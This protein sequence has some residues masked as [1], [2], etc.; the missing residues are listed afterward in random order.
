[1]ALV[2]LLYSC[3]LVGYLALRWPV[4]SY[5]P[6]MADFGLVQFAVLS[7]LVLIGAALAARVSFPK[8]ASHE[9]C[10]RWF[11]VVSLLG[12][13]FL[14]V[15]IYSLHH[16][17]SS[18]LLPGVSGGQASSLYRIGPGK[19]LHSSLDVYYL[20]SVGRRLA[21]LSVELSNSDARQRG[22]TLAGRE[23]VVDRLS[24]DASEWTTELVARNSPEASAALVT[25][26]CDVRPI[27]LFRSRASEF[28]HSESQRLSTQLQDLASSIGQIQVAQ[29]VALSDMQAARADQQ[30]LERESESVPS[31]GE[32]LAAERRAR[33]S[34]A[35]E[36][37][38]QAA[39]AATEAQ[40]ELRRAND[41][42]T[43]ATGRLDYL[44]EVGQNQAGVNARYPWLGLPVCIPNGW[45]WV[46][47][48]LIVT[49]CHIGHAVF[50]LVESWGEL[51]KSDN[52]SADLPRRSWQLGGHWM[53]MA[54]SWTSFVLLWQL[55]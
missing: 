52:E 47:A 33:L 27:D 23:Q 14:A 29:Q 55:G 21:E 43:K 13:L 53:V 42:Q 4:G 46:V 31:S 51:R 44:R 15:Q 25:L 6:S 41:L 2:I 48:Y 40:E 38:R 17:A 5:W 49:C 10:R 35:R 9:T 1:M 18:S 24:R 22:D 28:R 37:V 54:I 34:D 12:L 45:K 39:T 50:G 20:S 16:L 8:S 32:A 30:K 26:A 11:G 36:T 7:A 3:L 19:G